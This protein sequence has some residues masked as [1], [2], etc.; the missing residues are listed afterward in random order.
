VLH[1]VCSIQKM[2]LTGALQR[3]AGAYAK[4]VEV[5]IE[6]GCCGF[7]G[8][9]GFSLPELTAAALAP[10][11]AEVARLGGAGHYSTSL[12][13]EIGLTRA[14]GRGYRSFW[15]LIDESTS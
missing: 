12:T 13:C 14:T 1:P 9:R 7:A 4:R 10:E 8:D 5:P 15:H 6:A 11:A 3:V 2:E